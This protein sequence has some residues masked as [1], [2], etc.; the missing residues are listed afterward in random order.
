MYINTVYMNDHITLCYKACK[1]CWGKPLGNEYFDMV[2]FI[3]NR[4]KVSH[5]S[6]LE[7]SNVVM[8]LIFDSISEGYLLE[9]FMNL[10]G[11]MK[12]LNIA[13]VKDD[14]VYHILIG[15]SIRAY[16]EMIRTATSPNSELLTVILRELTANLDPCYFRDFINAG[17]CNEDEFS[18][19]CFHNFTKEDTCY[20]KATVG[21]SIVENVDPYEE[22]FMKLSDP[23]L[24]STADLY[25][26]LTITINFT[27]L[28]RAASHQLVR[29]RN[30]ITQSS[31][32]YIDQAEATYYIPD[33]I[34]DKEFVFNCFG[35]EVHATFEDILKEELHIYRQ[36]REQG[37]VKEDARGILG[38]NIASKDLYMT[39]T[40][41]TFIKFL[42]LRTDSHAQEEIRKRAL[43]LFDHFVNKTALLPEN[44][45]D[46]LI[47]YFE[48][49]KEEMVELDAEIDEMIEEKLLEMEQTWDNYDKN[50]YD[51]LPSEKA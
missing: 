6:V 4:V 21:L 10:V 29:H 22:L 37:A 48:I 28:S 31:M 19:V 25:R 26:M 34:K 5:E 20:N 40:Y 9:E 30:G 8:E 14:T 18:R 32:R 47:P 3:E 41:K 44:L 23:Y 17:L 12:Y 51:Y 24:F 1:A 33:S 16:K 42:E 36:I 38:S 43:D 7:H 2:K 11:D 35:Y 13:T 45:Y 27:D 50:V 15:G 39:F 46:Y 49:H